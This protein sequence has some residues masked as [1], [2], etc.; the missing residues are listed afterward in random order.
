MLS[1]AI[2]SEREVMRP[3]SDTWS[4]SLIWAVVPSVAVTTPAGLMV[5]PFTS[6]LS[7]R[8]GLLVPSSVRMTRPLCME[9]PSLMPSAFALV[10]VLGLG[11]TW[12]GRV[13]CA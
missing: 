11:A 2:I 9:R 10:A 7:A 5:V 3:V 8:S 13:V 4:P 1:A 12:P 6:F